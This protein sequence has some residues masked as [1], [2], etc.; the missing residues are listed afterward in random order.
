MSPTSNG[1]A[2][3][4]YRPDIVRK[5]KLRIVPFLAVLY[6]IAFIDRANV[7][8]AALGMNSD[9]GITAVQFGF[10][11]GL[12]SIG[13]FAFEVPSNMLMRR[14]GARRWIARI[15]FSW[16]LVAVLTGLVQNVTQ[17]A[18]AR[19]LLG[20]AEAGFFPCVLL[21]LSQWFPERERARVVAQFMVALPVATLIA[22]P[23]SG[24]ILDHVH[25]LDL[26]SWRWVFILEGMPA[27]LLGVIT[28]FVLVDAP[29]QAQWLS[30]AEKRWLT[31]TLERE[32]AAKNARHRQPGF[33]RSLLGA[34]VLALSLI[35]YS[36][37]VA[38]YVLAFFTPQIVQGLGQNLSHS[39]VGVLSALPYGAAAVVMVWW[40]RHSDRTRERRW[41]V[42]V[43]LFVCAA[44]LCAMPFAE[45]SLV[46]SLL[47]LTVVTVAV[48][49]TYGPFWSLPSLFLTGP[50]VAVG[51]AS[52]N[53]IANLGGFVGPFGFGA[54][55]T[56]TGDITAGLALVAIVLVISGVLVV[57]LRFV[58]DAEAALRPDDARHDPHRTDPA[59]QKE[60][61]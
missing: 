5:I 25:W 54:L 13:Y 32:N 26:A 51:L 10:I 43:P 1:A 38:I 45:G 29:S 33:W 20:I 7:G 57:R 17:L 48:Y 19:T 4:H 46:T 41:H 35:Y 47:L 55:E 50:A 30:A 52:I 24:L 36:K 58:R 23:L 16:G 18:I 37:S 56:A 2:P 8:Y 21:Y 60:I 44:G 61:P 53:S 15:L 31:D 40:A 28:L 11:A 6:I 12:F 42:A 49:A 3:G 14:V 9:L 27:V 59:L 34:R 22:G 39:T